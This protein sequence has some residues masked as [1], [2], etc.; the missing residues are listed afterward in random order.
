M[1][2]ADGAAN[3]L[4]SIFTGVVLLVLPAKAQEHRFEDDL[5][6]MVRENFVA[7][8]VLS[9]LQRVR[10]KNRRPRCCPHEGTSPCAGTEGCEIL[11]GPREFH[12]I[13]RR[14]QGYSGTLKTTTPRSSTTEM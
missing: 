6:L 9:Q 3:T 14:S 4:R 11:P 13:L 10:P 5:I 2:H 1:V 7:C 8:D 12:A